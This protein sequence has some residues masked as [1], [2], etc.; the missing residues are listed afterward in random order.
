MFWKKKK[1]KAKQIVK[2]TDD[3]SENYFIKLVLMGDGAVGKTSLRRNYLGMGFTEEHIM[4]IGA[5]FAAKD[6]SYKFGGK[7]YNITYQIWDLAGQSTFNSVRSM[8]YKGCFGGLLVFD[9]TRPTSFEN[10]PNWLNELKK[11]SSR[12]KVPVIILGNKA[13]LVE[14]ADPETVVQDEKV[15]EFVEK[16]NEEYADEKFNIIYLSTSAKTGLNVEE[17]FYFMAGS[18]LSWLGILKRPPQSIEDLKSFENSEEG[19]KSPEN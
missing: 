13:D 16:L 19:E 14:N 1:P 11:H 4:T 5:D 6:V 12:G 7:Q 18:I 9:R 17:A 3:G 2:K 8:Y 15:Q 10:I